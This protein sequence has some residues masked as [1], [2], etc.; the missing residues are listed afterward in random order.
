VLALIAGGKTAH[1]VGIILGIA[2]RTVDEHV[3]TACRKLGAAN[4]PHAVAIA[5]Q[6]E[7]I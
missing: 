7:I 2:K 6:R 1:E 4:R 5:V 3:V